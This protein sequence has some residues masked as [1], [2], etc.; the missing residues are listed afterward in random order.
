VV[1][2]SP[3]TVKVK[4]LSVT[5]VIEYPLEFSTT[6][7][8]KPSN[9]STSLNLT[10][11]PVLRPCPGSLTVITDVPELPDLNPLKGRRTVTSGSTLAGRLI[12]KA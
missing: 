10:V 2:V 8:V 11:S 9:A 4:V 6:D 3:L 5:F 7:D 12:L 1:A